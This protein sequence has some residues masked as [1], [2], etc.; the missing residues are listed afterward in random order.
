[1]KDLNVVAITRL[2][3]LETKPRLWG[4][5]INIVCYGFIHGGAERVSLK[6]IG[7][8]GEAVTAELT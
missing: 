2:N 1:M 6:F 8:A 7:R 4:R 3:P 5:K